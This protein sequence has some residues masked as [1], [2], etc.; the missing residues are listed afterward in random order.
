[1]KDDNIWE[2]TNILSL[3]SDGADL[4]S[5]KLDAKVDDLDMS[6]LNGPNKL[7]NSE[8]SGYEPASFASKT[9]RTPIAGRRKSGLPP[10]YPSPLE[11]WQSDPRDTSISKANSP[12]IMNG[13]SV[14][15]NE[16]ELTTD[17]VKQVLATPPKVATVSF[18]TFSIDHHHASAN[19][20]GKLSTSYIGIILQ[21][22]HGDN[23]ILK[24]VLYNNMFKG[25]F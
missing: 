11:S 25:A 2:S 22:H 19:D 6:F 12:P 16:K 14:M 3:L 20:F 4:T 10:T 18:K 5:S 21:K 8:F 23:D 15:R 7:S 9:K 17:D 13:L 1:M 24:Y